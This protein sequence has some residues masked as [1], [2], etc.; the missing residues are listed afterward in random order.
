[1]IEQDMPAV[2]A[3]VGGAIR[4]P[5]VRPVPVPVRPGQ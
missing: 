4:F 1:M 3:A 2:Y 5:E